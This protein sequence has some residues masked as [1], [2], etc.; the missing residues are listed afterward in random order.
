[1]H[2]TI[3]IIIKDPVV[4]SNLVEMWSVDFLHVWIINGSQ[5][6]NKNAQ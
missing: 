2:K 3:F 1:M 5:K 4:K 6:A